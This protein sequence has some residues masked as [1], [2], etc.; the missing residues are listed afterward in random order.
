MKWNSWKV[1][2]SAL[3]VG[4]ASFGATLHTR[5]SD[6]T[7]VLINGYDLTPEELHAVQLQTGARIP[8]GNYLPMARVSPGPLR[9]R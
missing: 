7:F 5:A 9:R 3:L 2:V 1:H 8:P 6:R 4:F